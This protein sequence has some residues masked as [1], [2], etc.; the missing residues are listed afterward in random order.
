AKGE[1]AGPDAPELTRSERRIL[2]LLFR[3]GSMTQATLAEETELTQ[4]SVSRIVARLQDQGMLE[5]GARIAS[6]R[7]GY[8]SATVKIAPG[9]TY[10][11]GVSIMAD[12][13]SVAA[14][15]FSG[16]VR[17][18]IRRAFSPMRLGDVT[19]WINGVIDQI[20]KDKLPK[21]IG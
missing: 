9:Y 10:S 14:I 17:C 15:D 19:E 6:G 3:R 4:Q 20:R 12:A 8:P 16:T 1:P 13:T 21:Q 7:R 5:T 11:L 2:G 18:E